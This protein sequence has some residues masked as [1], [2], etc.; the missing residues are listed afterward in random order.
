MSQFLVDAHPSHLEKTSTEEGGALQRAKINF[1]VDTYFTKINGPF[2]AALRAT[3]EEKEKAAAEFVEAIGKE[4]EPLLVD[5]KPFFGGASRLTLAEVLISFI[6][7][8]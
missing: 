5:A 4:I 2:F 1:F 8:V 3:G 7:K 6:P